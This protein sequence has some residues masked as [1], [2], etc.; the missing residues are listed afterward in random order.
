M[1]TQHG[2][3][4]GKVGFPDQQVDVAH[5][6]EGE[7]AICGSRCSAVHRFGQIRAFEHDDGNVVLVEQGENVR[8][9]MIEPHIAGGGAEVMLV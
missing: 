8:Q 7:A 2:L 3:A 4:S 9:F 5:R 1:L 6:P